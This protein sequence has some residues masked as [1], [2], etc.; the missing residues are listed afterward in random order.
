MD[1]QDPRAGAVNNLVRILRK[2]TRIV[3]I[4]P[5]AYLVLLASY[6]LLESILPEWVVGISDNL[7]DTPLYTT[8]GLLGVGR[9]LKLCKWFK[10]ACILPVSAKV[11]GYVDSFLYTFTQVEV[12]WINVILSIIFILFIVSA[13]RHFFHGR[14]ADTHR[15]S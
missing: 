13:N 3:Q 10:A 4:A 2:I 7:V 6:L 11:E 1:S 9:L 14:K 15:N 8:V 5:F 12:I